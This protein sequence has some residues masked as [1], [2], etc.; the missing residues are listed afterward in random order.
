MDANAGRDVDLDVQSLQGEQG[1]QGELGQS[2]EPELACEAVVPTFTM[3]VTNTTDQNIF[4]QT[5]MPSGQGV[6]ITNPDVKP[7]VEPPYV[8]EVIYDR[9]T[10]IQEGQ[11]RNSSLG[12]QI[13]LKAPLGGGGYDIYWDWKQGSSPICKCTPWDPTVL[14]CTCTTSGFGTLCVT[15]SITLLKGSG[16]E[17]SAEGAEGE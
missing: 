13:T 8:G 4:V 7:P 10:W 3:K 16:S 9:V 15:C 12:G 2:G 5:E 17:P 14:T 1:E 6:W 11:N